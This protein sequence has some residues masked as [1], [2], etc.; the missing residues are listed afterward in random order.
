MTSD[1]NHTGIH[2]KA[3]MG[4]EH[5]SIPSRKLVNQFEYI[6]AASGGVD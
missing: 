3:G 6:C 5:V 2:R 1:V 4:W